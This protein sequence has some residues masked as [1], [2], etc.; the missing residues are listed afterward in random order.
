MR[1]RTQ[2]ALA[3]AIADRRREI[4]AERAEINR[5]IAGQAP[6]IMALSKTGS[7]EQRLLAARWLA[8]AGKEVA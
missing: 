4:A 7:P 1:T 3:M 8:K 2:N 5:R 6:S